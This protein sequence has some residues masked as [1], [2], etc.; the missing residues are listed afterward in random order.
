MQIRTVPKCSTAQGLDRWNFNELPHA[1]EDFLTPPVEV[2]SPFAELKH[3]C[4]HLSG[5]A[6]TVDKTPDFSKLI[7]QNLAYDNLRGRAGPE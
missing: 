6:K 5:R 1:I 3:H 4:N 2:F 7:R